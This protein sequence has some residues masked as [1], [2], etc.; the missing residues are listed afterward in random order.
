[1]RKWLLEKF[2]TFVIWYARRDPFSHIPGYMERYWILHY[3]RFMPYSI[4]VHHILRSDLDRHLHDHPWPYITFILRGGYWEVTDNP[5][6]L[7][8]V[9]WKWYG[10]GSI[11][12]R[13]RDHRHRLELPFGTTTWTVFMMGRKVN[14]WGFFTPEGK[15]PWRTYLRRKGDHHEGGKQPR[16]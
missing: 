8:G 1:M 15:V 14:N 2:A 16:A 12:I 3:R 9:Q 11:L 10:P 7:T 13:G 6:S 4:R 5:H